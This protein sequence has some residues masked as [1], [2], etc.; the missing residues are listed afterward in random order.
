MKV[1]KDL[2]EK[3]VNVHFRK[4]NLDSIDT[5]ND[6]FLT[7][8][9][10]LAENENKM[11]SERFKWKLNRLHLKGGWSAPPPYG[12]NLKGKVQKQ[13]QYKEHKLKDE[14]NEDD[15]NDS[16]LEEYLDDEDDDRNDDD[17]GILEINQL[18]AA[19][20]DF[21]FYLY[22]ELLLSPAKIAKEFNKKG[23]KTKK[24]KE[25]NECGIRRFLNNRICIGDIE[26]HKTETY[27][28]TRGTK[29]NIPEEER[30]VVHKEELRI[31]SDELWQKKER[32]REE[33]SKNSKGGRK[34]GYS[35]QNLFSS[36][37]YCELCGS[38]FVRKKRKLVKGEN[39][40]KIDRGYEWV[41][42]EYDSNGREKC[43]RY[44]VPEDELIAAIKK[45]LKRKK[46]QNDEYVL[47]AYKE[48]K[49][50]E[51]EKIKIDDLR[52]EIED[53][54]LQMIELR[55][56]KNKK[57]IDVSSYE[58]QI[59]V[60]NQRQKEIRRLQNKYNNINIDIERVE[61]RYREHRNIIE[62]IDF[63]NL[64]NALL[65]QIFKKIKILGEI[66]EGYK[67]YYIH[68]NYNFLDEPQTEL[69]RENIDGE[70]SITEA[71]FPLK[72]EKLR[73]RN[74]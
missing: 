39:G 73:F 19:R 17:V 63:N 51:R 21:G 74:M 70:S 7:N 58:E 6:F 22:T 25:W 36:L 38:P 57:M 65:K 30:I 29:K 9:F 49:K 48:Q 50:I 33:K 66:D 71:F 23:W 31:I 41:C 15:Y 34:R 5:R 10:A 60:L 26:N 24:G 72:K 56:E 53:I 69:L 67:Y 62:N 12:Y 68:Y 43:F 35:T 14:N 16:D 64:T 20:V 37:V 32:V 18:E 42:Y 2:R 46:K 4:E 44:A 52:E 47:E 11:K 59:K 54:N 45:E 40:T 55:K 8:L 3:N 27:D 13:N 61:S 28:I 1:I